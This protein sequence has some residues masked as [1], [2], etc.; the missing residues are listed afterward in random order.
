MSYVPGYNYLFARSNMNQHDVDSIQYQLGCLANQISSNKC[1]F[2]FLPN[3]PGTIFKN[4]YDFVVYLFHK[5]FD[6]A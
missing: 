6:D 5:L 3:Q 2:Y 4:N 1:G